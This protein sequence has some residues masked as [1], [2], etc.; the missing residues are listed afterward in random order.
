M[1]R[2]DLDPT[3]DP[4]DPTS[5]PERPR[6]P[7][8]G[9]DP[10]S[11]ETQDTFEIVSEAGNVVPIVYGT[12]RV[13][14]QLLERYPNAI[15]SQ[16]N[17]WLPNTAYSLGNV[18][19]SNGN[20]YLCTAGGTSF[21]STYTLGSATI[22]A[23]G[24][25]YAVNDTIDL[26]LGVF[27]TSNSSNRA[28]LKVT[29]IGGGG[30]VTVVTVNAAGVG[31]TRLP[32]NPDGQDSTSGGGSGATFGLSW[33]AG[34]GP[35]GTGDNITGGTG[36]LVWRYLY[37]ASIRVGGAD[38]WKPSTPY[39]L[40][41][42]VGSNGN[43]YYCITAGTSSATGSLGAGPSSQ[44]ADVT[45]GTVHW[46]YVAAG[47]TIPCVL[48]IC[49]GQIYGVIGAWQDS[50]T[51]GVYTGIPHPGVQMQLDLGSP[52]GLTR[53]S[54]LPVP[55]AV[56][57][58][59]Y[60]NTALLSMVYLSAGGD[61]GMPNISLEVAGLFCDATHQDVSPCDIVIDL[62]T[63]SRRGIG[64]S[65]TRVDTASTGAG[66]AS[67]WR[68]YCTAYGLNL[69][70][71]L[72]S[73]VSVLDLL[74]TLLKATNTDCVWTNRPD[75]AGGML[76]FVPRADKALTANGVTF[77]P[78]ATA[79]TI[80]PD[81]LLAP[82][83]VS[84]RRS[85]DC[86]NSFPV[87]FIDRAQAYRRVVVD[88]PDMVDVDRRGLMR[89]ST[90]SLSGVVMQPASAVMLSRIFAQ[91]S[92]NVRNTYTL[93]LPWKYM[94]LEPTDLIS[95]TDSVLGLVNQPMRIVSVDEQDASLGSLIVTAEDFGTSVHV[96]AQV[97][98]QS[99]GPGTF[100]PNQATAVA[101][102]EVQPQQVAPSVVPGSSLTRSLITNVWPN[103]TSQQAPP[104][105][106]DLRNPEWAGRVADA[107]AFVGDY[108]RQLSAPLNAS[109]VLGDDY[110]AGG[111]SDYTSATARLGY[112]F[113]VTAGEVVLIAAQ[114]RLTQASVGTVANCNVKFLDKNKKTLTSLV[115]RGVALTYAGAGL[116]TPWQKIMQM[117]VPPAGAM[118]VYVALIA[119]TNSG[120][121]TAQFD[122]VQV[123]VSLP[124][125]DWAAL[126]MFNG[127]VAF[128]GGWS[129]PS[130]FRDLFGLVHVRG[131]ITNPGATPANTIIA[132]LPLPFSPSV[133]MLLPG[134]NV[135]V[136]ASTFQR[137]DIDNAG[138]I[139]VPVALVANTI[140]SLDGL[141]F[142]LR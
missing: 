2:T 89:A 80:G 41:A 52:S 72:D 83:K 6:G 113:P 88:D 38:P 42:V 15:G 21:P 105:G 33:N 1:L 5:R 66:T 9:L 64:W 23:G 27:D 70:F 16:N 82:I 4:T 36:G 58:D 53:P 48:G 107:A 140:L 137:F 98:P 109:L 69:S 132:I 84:R 46:A 91:R 112:I 47:F 142:D 19:V 81:D 29:G 111:A 74:A 13:G 26:A 22:V 125:D 128:G 101:R 85:T 97:T 121:V 76:K 99:A 63:H 32:P 61:G 94:L 49:E 77:T 117:A 30:A 25:G 31:Y 86:L 115:I 39:A 120:A 45:D 20:V 14:L 59:V 7:K 8:S 134:S 127:W 43:L 79:T 108:V 75:G 37:P 104:S 110:V 122:A 96:A 35:F 60:A 130:Y 129:Q 141:Y 90:T 136:A 55:D 106:A 24:A 100:I 40:N 3:D 119:T 68:N 28:Q 57:T 17:K 71:V 65:A 50:A 114:A 10:Q 103:P 124:Q 126:N 138:N 62:L 139:F 95:V 18:V 118:Y 67:S 12:G 51:M 135:S 92:L 133:H 54:W 116:P 11:S 131:I 34:G 56:L 93:Q 78:N 44:S 102:V 123:S 87:E 73:Q